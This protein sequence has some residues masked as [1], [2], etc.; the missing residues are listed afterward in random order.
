M[1]AKHPGGSLAGQ[2]SRQVALG[3]ILRAQQTSV[4]P[5][6]ARGQKGLGSEELYGL[7]LGDLRKPSLLPMSETS[8]VSL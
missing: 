2:P 7:K 6:E 4:E 3:S 8:V 5:P 1:L